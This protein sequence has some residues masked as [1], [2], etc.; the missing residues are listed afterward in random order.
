MPKTNTDKVIPNQTYAL[1]ENEDKHCT[2]I[3]LKS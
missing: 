3:K 1:S 2:T